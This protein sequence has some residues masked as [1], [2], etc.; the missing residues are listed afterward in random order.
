MAWSSLDYADRS[1]FIDG[2]QSGT[3]YGIRASD[4]CPEEWIFRRSLS[5]VTCND[6]RFFHY[7]DMPRLQI[8]DQFY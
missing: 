6:R 5:T 7:V 2:N 4:Q 1:I 3:H 8:S